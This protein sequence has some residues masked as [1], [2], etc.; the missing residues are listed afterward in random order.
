MHT[1][2]SILFAAVLLCLTPTGSSAQNTTSG[3]NDPLICTSYKSQDAWKISKPCGQWF[4]RYNGANWKR[5]CGIKAA[6]EPM[7]DLAAK[8]AKKFTDACDC[9]SA[10]SRKKRK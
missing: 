1:K 3:E 7:L 5:H 4:M 6:D 2:M 8:A 9:S 10:C